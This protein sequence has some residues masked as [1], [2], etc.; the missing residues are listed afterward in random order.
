MEPPI[1]TPE[2]MTS[3]KEVEPPVAVLV[4]VTHD[5]EVLGQ[6]DNV[7]SIV[8][9]MIMILEESLG[10]IAEDPLHGERVALEV[11]QISLLLA[12]RL[13]PLLLRP[14]SHKCQLLIQPWSQPSLHPFWPSHKVAIRRDNSFLLFVY[15]PLKLIVS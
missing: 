13:L 9:Y 11:R 5:A 12:L 14:T 3:E 1:P 4:T 10:S 15:N 6:E 7:V 2:V 8:E